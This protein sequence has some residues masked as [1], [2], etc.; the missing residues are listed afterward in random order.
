MSFQQALPLL[1]ELAENAD[2][3]AAIVRVRSLCSFENSCSLTMAT[4]A[5][6]AEHLR[7]T[8]MGRTAR[9]T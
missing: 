3:V 4:A 7:E 6:R 1:T 9:Y 8:V 2:F 5:R